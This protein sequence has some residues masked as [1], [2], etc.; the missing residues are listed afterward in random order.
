MEIVGSGSAY[1]AVIP[2]ILHNV[3]DFEH[4]EEF[5]QLLGTAEDLPG[6]VAAAYARYMARL[7]ASGLGQLDVLVA[8]LNLMASWEDDRV[9]TMLRD[10]AIEQLEADGV[11]D[12]VEPMFSDK[13]RTIVRS[14]SR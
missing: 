4:S 6:V 9:D 5:R 14:E 12:R 8:P 7:I 3:P 11:L 10:E 2:A 1:D 13:L